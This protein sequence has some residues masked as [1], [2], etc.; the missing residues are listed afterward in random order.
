MELSI[1][2]MRSWYEFFMIIEKP[3]MF[4][5]NIASLRAE[6]VDLDG[7]SLG[8]WL[9]YFKMPEEAL[10]QVVNEVGNLAIVVESVIHQ[11]GLMLLETNY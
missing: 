4:S 3:F 11:T 8:Y 6:R 5:S 1:F 2:L 10:R 9:D 7:D